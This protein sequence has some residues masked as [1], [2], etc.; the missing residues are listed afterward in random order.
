MYTCPKSDLILSYLIFSFLFVFVFPLFSLFV[1][2]NPISLSPL[3]VAP[4][5]CHVCM[6]ELFP[7]FSFF[8]FLLSLSSISLHGHLP[9]LHLSGTKGQ[10]ALVTQPLCPGKL[11]RLE[12]S[13]PTR[14][15]WARI[16]GRSHHVLPLQITLHRHLFIISGCSWHFWTPCFILFPMTTS[17]PNET[18]RIFGL[19]T[20]EPRLS[21]QFPAKGCPLTMNQPLID[22]LHAISFEKRYILSMFGECCRTEFNI[23]ILSLSTLYE[24]RPR[25]VLTQSCKPNTP[26]DSF[27]SLDFKYDLHFVIWLTVEKSIFDIF[28]LA[29]SRIHLRA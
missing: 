24:T 4:L 11:L 10:H 14:L 29:N 13:P 18:H 22:H 16:A 5:F 27:W 7:L 15:W 19:F 9:K 28:N 26:C 23:V 3:F 8:S 2:T 1:P 17:L 21:N 25:E 20:H 12:P 6:L